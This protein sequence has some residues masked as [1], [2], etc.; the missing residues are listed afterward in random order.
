MPDARNR[1]W[2]FKDDKNYEK[3]YEML[4]E[5]MSITCEAAGHNFQSLLVQW[6]RANFDDLCADWFETHWTGQVKGR[7]LLGSCS[8]GLVSSNQSLHWPSN[9]DGGGIAMHA[10]QVQ[11]VR[12]NQLIRP[13]FHIHPPKFLHT[14]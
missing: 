5:I 9:L 13:I 2:Y 14:P 4:C 6:L 10:L 3:F 11:E 1:Q 8:V 12:L 7:Y